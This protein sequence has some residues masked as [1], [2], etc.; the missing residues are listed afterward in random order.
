MLSVGIT[1][2]I[3][4]EVGS[5]NETQYTPPRITYLP[6]DIRSGTHKGRH[7]PLIAPETENFQAF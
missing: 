1:I 4:L 7:I 3:L 2:V 5:T 6:D